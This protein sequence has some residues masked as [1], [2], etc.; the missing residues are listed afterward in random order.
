MTGAHARLDADTLKAHFRSSG[1]VSIEG[2]LDPEELSTLRRELTRVIAHVVPD[3]PQ[4]DVYR[5]NLADSVS[6]KQIQR[7]HVH[8]PTLR[9]WLLDGPFA[10][11]A[12]VLLEDEP[13]AQN[14]Q[15]FDK[16]PGANQATPPHQDGAY[17]PIKPMN[18]VTLWLALE[19]VGLEQGCVHYVVGSHL[20]GLRPHARSH[21]LGFSREL[22][23]YGAKDASREQA[24]PCAAG[25]VI[26]HH[27]LTVHRAN[28]NASPN[29]HRRALGFIYYGAACAIDQG[30]RDGYQQQLDADLHRSGRLAPRSSR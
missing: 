16:A 9:N 25:H 12:A 13:A 17:F 4:E 22:A 10:Q 27:P 18:A 11:L 3:I 8:D 5:E 23:E 30:A 19:D 20:G 26:A 21:T 24:F 28:G 29:H 2:F 14:L 1:F 6:L 15:Y 7:L